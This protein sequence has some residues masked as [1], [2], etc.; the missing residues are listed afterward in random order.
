MHPQLEIL[1]QIQDLKAQRRELTAGGD[2]HRIEEKEFHINVEEALAR[3]DAKAA[4]LEAELT[5][6]VRRRYEQVSGGRDRAVVPVINGTCYGCF[7]SLPTARVSELIRNDE[8][9]HCDN[10]GCFLY[11]VR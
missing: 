5:P 10:C 6:A 11:G 1:L 2:E 8:I 9:H 4:E 3:L 7:V